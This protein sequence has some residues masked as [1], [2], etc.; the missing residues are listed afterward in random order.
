MDEFEELSSELFFE[1]DEI[2]DKSFMKR[3]C[4]ENDAEYGTVYSMTDNQL[5]QYVSSRETKIKQYFKRVEK[6]PGCLFKVGDRMF[7]EVLENDLTT[8]FGSRINYGERLC[9]ISLATDD[10]DFPELNIVFNRQEFT[11]LQSLMDFYIDESSLLV[12][13]DIFDKNKTYIGTDVFIAGEVVVTTYSQKM[14]FKFKNNCNY[15]YSIKDFQD[16]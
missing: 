1:L 5:H 15:N 10:W 4:V 8:S 11:M 12:Y 9:G 6:L 13:G 3:F 7:K 16:E 2:Y 14:F